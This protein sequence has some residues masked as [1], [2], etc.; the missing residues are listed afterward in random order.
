MITEHETLHLRL[1]DYPGGVALWGAVAPVYDTTQRQLER[2][3]HVHARTELKGKK[4]MDWTVRAVRLSGNG[5]SGTGVVVSEL[6]AIYYMV[7]SVFGYETR[8]VECTHC[9]FPHLDRDWFSVHP[10]RRHLCAGCGK[11]FRD[12]AIGIGNPI[13]IVR[14]ACGIGPSATK[15]AGRTLDIRQSDYPGGI[16]IW[17]SNPAFLWTSSVREE[18]GIHVHASRT[19]DEQDPVID[20]PTLRSGSTA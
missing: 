4:E 6:D 12:D 18:E 14:A 7:S 19:D 20:E 3:I 15:P 1:S 17:G 2:G 10:H 16:Q 9:G 11:H 5:L 13:E 8:R